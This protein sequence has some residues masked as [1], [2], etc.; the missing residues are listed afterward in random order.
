MSILTERLLWEAQRQKQDQSLESGTDADVFPPESPGKPIRASMMQEIS[1]ASATVQDMTY[2]AI[3]LA[4]A[5]Y[6]SGDRT[7]AIAN[8]RDMLRL[9]P[10]DDQGVRFELAPMLVGAGQDQEAA[11]LLETYS[12]EISSAWPYLSA[13]LLYR[14]QGPTPTAEKALRR[15]F[16]ANPNVLMCLA[17]DDACEPPETFAIGDFDEAVVIVRAQ[18]DAWAKSPGFVEWMLQ[19]GLEQMGDQMI[20]ALADSHGSPDKEH[21]SAPNRP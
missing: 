13:L 4:W 14:A 1:S 7:G 17:T 12:D 2:Q 9:S 6:H 18:H 3:L 21:N 11:D 20:S 8:F 15:A 16:R 10:K 19:L 5:C